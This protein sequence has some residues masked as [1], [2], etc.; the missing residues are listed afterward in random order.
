MEKYLHM[1]ERVFLDIIIIGTIQ[2]Y[3]RALVK[4]VEFHAIAML[5]QPYY[6]YPNIQKPKKNLISL[7]MVEYISASTLKFLI[8]I[9][10]GL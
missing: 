2:N 3:I 7:Y 5:V 8:F 10:T 9:I 4:L 1:R 6:L